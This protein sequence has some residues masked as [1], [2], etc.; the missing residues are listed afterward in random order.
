MSQ[1]PAKTVNFNAS[2]PLTDVT[3]TSAGHADETGLGEDNLERL[4]HL[5]PD[6]D[7]CGA[8]PPNELAIRLAHRAIRALR[9]AGVPVPNISPSVEEGVCLWYRREGRYA[10]LE[11]FNTGEVV[12]VVLDEAGAH[13]TFEVAQS[14]V[15]IMGA[16]DRIKSH[17]EKKA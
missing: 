9:V 16:A 12:G 6:W 10:D 7:E 15:A 5:P 8:A 2:D 3:R 14:D 13:Q 4:R 17:L 11:C 1:T